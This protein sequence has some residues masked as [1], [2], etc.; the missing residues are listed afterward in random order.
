MDEAALAEAVAVAARRKLE[1]PLQLTGEMG[2]DAVFVGAGAGAPAF[3][4]IPGEFAGQVYSANE[5]LT[6]VNLM[7]GD[8]FPYQDTPITLGKSVV[9]A[10][11]TPNFIANRVGIAGM[12][13]TMKE[14]ETYGLSYD[15]VDDLT[16]KKMGR[17]SSGTFRTADVVGLDTMAHVIK[18]MQD[19]LQADPFY[20][21]FATPKVLAGLID[22]TGMIAPDSSIWEV[23][24]NGRQ[25]RY[26]YTSIAA[27]TGRVGSTART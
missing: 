3:L 17:A 5:F 25:K 20:P 26:S 15:V 23:H 21:H 7:G 18:T 24:W 1:A 8:K 14:A 6:R 22:Q 27:V 2:F 4:G 11:D 10:K 16:G 13:A 9:R 12:L 19:T